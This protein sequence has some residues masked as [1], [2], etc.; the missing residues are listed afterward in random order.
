MVSA[1]NANHL[2]CLN[3]SC[4]TFPF[5]LLE[6]LTLPLP[7]VYASL[8]EPLT[9]PL[10]LPLR[11]L[12]RQA[13]RLSCKEQGELVRVAFHP[14]RLPLYAKGTHAAGWTRGQICE[15]AKVRQCTMP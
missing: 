11:N 5:P 4:L 9:L 2:S 10:P 12:Q 7:S 1:I 3:Q 14:V 15:C 8:L 13:Q 6:S